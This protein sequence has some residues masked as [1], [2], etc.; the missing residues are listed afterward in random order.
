MTFLGFRIAK[1][2]GVEIPAP[3]LVLGFSN[4]KYGAVVW[5]ASLYDLGLRSWLAAEPSGIKELSAPC[6]FY[7]TGSTFLLRVM[8]LPPAPLTGPYW[9]GPYLVNVP[10]LGAYTWNSSQGAIDGIKALDMANTGN[11]SEVIGVITGFSWLA[12]GR[13]A[14]SMTVESSEPVGTAQ[15][16]AQY[17]DSIYIKYASMPLDS[18]GQPVLQVGRRV[19]C[20]VTMIWDVYSYQWSAS[21]FYYYPREV[22]TFSGS[23]SRGAEVP[24]PYPVTDSAIGHQCVTISN[25]PYNLCLWQIHYSVSGKVDSLDLSQFRVMIGEFNIYGGLI[26]TRYLVGPASGSFN[27]E[28]LWYKYMEM[29]AHPDPNAPAWHPDTWSVEG[30]VRVAYLGGDMPG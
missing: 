28:D 19:T 6:S 2:D 5:D 12:E 9:L 4:P 30:W 18:L 8:E 20:R 7:P 3:T 11:S 21:A 25:P 22:C 29:Y 13:W 23:L 26:G 17:F 15:D 14:V 24:S 1:Y 10:E 16:F 27:V